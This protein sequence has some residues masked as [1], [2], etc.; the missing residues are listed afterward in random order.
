[1]MNDI[2]RRGALRRLGLAIGA[3][4]I[5]G[6]AVA[7]DLAQAETKTVAPPAMAS[8]ADI[9]PGSNVNGDYQ[10]VYH[11][12]YAQAFLALGFSEDFLLQMFS[13]VADSMAITA[14]ANALV[15]RAKSGRT[16][17][18]IRLG[19][20]ETVEVFGTKIPDR[21][22]RFDQPNRLV[23]TFTAPNGKRVEAVQTFHADG[24]VTVLSIDGAPH[25]K[26][27][28]IWKRVVK[29]EQAS[30]KLPQLFPL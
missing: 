15:L 9:E 4:G 16:E 7:Q 19:S 17:R 28:R 25:L 24:Y 20:P 27:V 6:C 14:T 1:M 2:D 23:I 5:F 30:H 21:Y 3:D 11:E 26:P 18:Q 29:N 12:G 22:A 10:A 13:E 8:A